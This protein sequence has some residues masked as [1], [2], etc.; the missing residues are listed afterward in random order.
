MQTNHKDIKLILNFLHKM[1]IEDG[2]DGE[3][4]WLTKFYKLEN[5]ISIIKNENIEPMWTVEL[6]EEYIIWGKDQENIYIT[7][8]SEIYN[9]FP[10][11]EIKLESH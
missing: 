11:A 7:N 4:V 5:I 6:L 9:K 3:A 10:K 1:V 8:N 2:G